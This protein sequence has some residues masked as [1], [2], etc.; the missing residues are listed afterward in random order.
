MSASTGTRRAY[1]EVTTRHREDQLMSAHPDHPAQGN[2]VAYQHPDL[3][4][5]LLCREHGE[6]WA[7]MVPLTS[8][9]LPDGGFCSW[10]TDDDM[11]VCGRAFRMKKR[12]S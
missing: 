4:G 11:T 10:G 1:R 2:I 6:Q 12:T 5:V 3:S 7:G 8:N 9:D